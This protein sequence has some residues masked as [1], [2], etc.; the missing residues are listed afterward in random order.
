M[1]NQNSF[2]DVTDSAGI[3]WSRQKGNESFSVA[4]LDFNNDNLPDLWISGHGY[5]RSQGFPVKYPFLYINNGDGTFTNL[6]PED[7]RSGSGGDTHG[8]TW[9]DFDNDGDQDVFV[10]VG[11][12]LGRGEGPNLF[13]VNNNDQLEEEA[14]ARGLEYVIGRG[15]SS[16]WFDGNGDGL[17]DV[18]LLEAVRPDGDGS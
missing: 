15:R 2:Q 5:G 3:V 7:W 18:L 1:L 11:A 12:N 9:I 16:L 4:W 10:S 17:L 14:S 8:T 6:F 13:F